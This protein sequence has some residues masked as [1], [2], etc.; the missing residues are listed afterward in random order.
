MLQCTCASAETCQECDGRTE[1][2]R[3]TIKDYEAL[4]PTLRNDD[5]VWCV[6]SL[7]SSRSQMDMAT[8]P[9]GSVTHARSATRIYIRDAGPPPPTRD[10]RQGALCLV[11]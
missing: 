2:L 4:L 10:T 3:Q 1:S 6:P 8:P 7:H 11:S 5:E 9:A